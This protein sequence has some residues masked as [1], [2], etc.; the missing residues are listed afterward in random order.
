[1][2]ADCSATAAAPSP[3]SPAGLLWGARGFSCVFWGVPLGIGLYFQALDLRQ[4]PWFRDVPPHLVGVVMVCAGAVM[5]VR[6]GLVTP[7]WRKAAREVLAAALLLAYLGPFVYWS[8]RLPVDSLYYQ[9]NLGLLLG[10][11]IWLLF[12]VNTV[13]AEVGIL[14]GDQSFVAESRLS[15]WVV[16]VLT[17]LPGLGGAIAGAILAGRYH[18]T[19]LA[20]LQ[21]LGRHLPFWIAMWLVIPLALSMSSAWKA[22][23]HCLALLRD[24]AAGRQSRDDTGAGVW[25]TP[26]A[27]GKA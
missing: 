18:S 7:G 6:A 10:G 20:E 25:Q 1:M 15:G 2:E 17:V 23:E 4:I 3:P 26:E 24:Q 16:L 8:A 22:K 19:M 27:G 9:G 5:L 11:L 21:G 12:R 13:A 14:A